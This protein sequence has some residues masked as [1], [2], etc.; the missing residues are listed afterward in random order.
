[1]SVL[2]TGGAGYI[3]SHMTLEL[4]DRGDQVVVL[5]NLVTGVRAQVSEKATFV[6][7]DISDKNLVRDI[8]KTHK[9]EAVIH[10]AGRCLDLVAEQGSLARYIWRFEPEPLD[11][12]EPVTETAASRALSRDLKRRGWKFV[13]PTTMYAFMQ[14]MGLLNDHAVGCV[15]REVVA[16]RLRQ[17]V[18]PAG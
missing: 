13:G 18:R 9:I 12:P 5:D 1:M 15:T 8:I 10:N 16:A 11:V 2:V 3:G 14:S 17:F 6:E 7:G 4:V